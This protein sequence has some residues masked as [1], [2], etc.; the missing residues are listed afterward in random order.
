MFCKFIHKRFSTLSLAV[1]GSGPGAIFTAKHLMKKHT[2]IVVDFYE[3]FPHPFGLIRTGVA[4]DHQDVKNIEHEFSHILSLP[5]TKF[6]GNVIVNKD[7]PLNLEILKKN[8][9]AVLLAYGAH[10]DIT[11]GIKN[12][13]CKGCFN[14]RNFVNWYNSSF[15]RI[16][17]D[18]IILNKTEDCVIIGNG[19]VAIDIARMLSKSFEDLKQFDVGDDV[20]EIICNNT[21]KNIHMVARRGVNQ[22]AFTTKEIR[23]LH[24]VKGLNTYIFEDEIKN[25]FEAD[26][27]LQV[28]PNERRQLKRKVDLVKSFDM[29]NNVN[30]IKKDGRKN[31]FLRFLNRPKEIISDNTGTISEIIFNKTKLIKGQAVATEETTSIKCGLLFKSIG[32]KSHSI[33]DTVDFN[34]KSSVIINDKGKVSENKVISDNLF[35]SGWVK[36]GAKGVLDT[37]LREAVDT[38]DTINKQIE[39]GFLK[40][41]TPNYDE[42]NSL[43]AKSGVKPISFKDWEKVSNYEIEEGKKKGKIRDKVTDINKVFELIKH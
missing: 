13:D 30:Q 35:V 14:S 24:G 17:N 34:S 25:S 36:T 6:F 12:E 5:Q 21:I 4:P 22:A 2:N 27:E 10:G 40:N 38:A 20:L 9:S 1:V 19:N 42:I 3:K 8:Y 26:S 39:G 18:K 37:T 16:S 41:K 29:I 7:T 31:L 23:E 15:D 32:Y 11:L 28:L 43:I 33:F